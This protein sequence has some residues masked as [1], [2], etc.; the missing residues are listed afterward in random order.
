MN[1]F[2][3]FARLTASL[4]VGCAALASTGCDE[5]A[6]CTDQSACAEGTFCDFGVGRCA[7]GFK[8]GT[9]TTIPE[10]CTLDYAPVCG[11]DGES[12]SNPCAADAAAVSVDYVG[13]CGA[14]CCDPFAQPGVGE[15]LPCFE[16]SACCADGQWH[17]NDGGGS[18]TCDGVGGA[19][20]EFCGGI[21]GLPCGQ[22]EF[23][24]IATGECC[25]DIEGVCVPTPEVC[26]EIFAP[27]CGCDG[28]TY[29]NSCSADAAGVNIDHDG[30]CGS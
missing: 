16:G 4:L 14:A 11:C 20:S 8:I 12:Y 7:D 22:G 9:C 26:T 30:E 28:E 18:S 27:V 17:C 19:C 21:A 13:I 29:S 3:R 10:T 15:S 23:C 5:T 1:A 2:S 25:C 24:K 6:I